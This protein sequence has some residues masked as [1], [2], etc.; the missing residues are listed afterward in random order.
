MKDVVIL[1]NSPAGYAC[2][3]T[4]RREGFQGR[5]VIIPGDGEFPYRRGALTGVLAKTVPL[6][7]AY[8]APEASYA[9]LNVQV[10]PKKIGRV[11]FKRQRLTTEDKEVIP[12][13]VCLVDEYLWL[14]PE[15]IKGT[16]R[17]GFLLL[18][19]LDHV[20]TALKQ[21]LYADTVLIQAD[22]LN[23]VR[24]AGALSGWD[25]EVI[26]IS[27]ADRVLASFVEP[28][29]SARISEELEKK[30]VRVLL[31]NSITEILGDSDLKAARL[32]S[33]KILAAQLVFAEAESPDYRLFRDTELFSD[34]VF[35][36]SGEDGATAYSNI[37]MAGRATGLI[38][39]GAASYG[40]YDDFLLE[41]GTAVA[42]QIF[43]KNIP[44]K[45]VVPQADVSL[46]GFQLTL[47]GHTA[48]RQER[49]AEVYLRSD[50]AAGSYQRF[51]IR[52]GV[53]EGAVL[54]NADLSRYQA[55]SFLSTRKFLS[56]EYLQNQGFQRLTP[57]GQ[58][59]EDASLDK[60]C[61]PECAQPCENVQNS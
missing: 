34:G 51:Y 22:S 7:K 50:E 60:D 24:T 14:P 4:L 39:P 31:E 25:K 2:L 32:K 49:A 58:G 26:L 42:A 38:S 15:D 28:E 47:L 48:A 6:E 10:C 17:N 23:G 41:Q 45:P 29:I 40:S 44:L 5:V 56:E 35:L 11:N 13:D 43:Q 33:G 8:C 30:G 3:H 1:G 52:D 37:F 57:S 16:G 27:S 61:S 36:P 12:F 18:N 55:L 53:L 9:P 54:I 20:K 21:L 19:R 59:S 46:P